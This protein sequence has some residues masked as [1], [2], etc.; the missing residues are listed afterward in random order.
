[1]QNIEREFHLHEGQERE[2]IMKLWLKSQSMISIL[3][4]YR[5]LLQDLKLDD[6][7]LLG[8]LKVCLTERFFVFIFICFHLENS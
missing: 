1:M 5:Y 8:G 2:I 7:D 4:R 6:Q 3:Y